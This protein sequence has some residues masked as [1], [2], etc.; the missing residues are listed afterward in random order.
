MGFADFWLADQ[1]T[2]L[3]PALLD[4]QYL[5]CFYL[6]NDKWMSNKSKFYTLQVDLMARLEYYTFVPS[7]CSH[8]HRWFQVCGTRMAIAAIC[9]MS[10]RMVP[11][12]AMPKTVPGL[13]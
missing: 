5:V 10:A 3:V 6:T 13:P 4:F 7:S 11:I 2:S 9:R 8:R 12:H 1:L